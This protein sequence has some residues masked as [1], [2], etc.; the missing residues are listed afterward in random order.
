[1]DWKK[2]D[3]VGESCVWARCHDPNTAQSVCV[4]L[5]AH[6]KPCLGN[7]AYGLL[8]NICIRVAQRECIH[9]IL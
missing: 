1:M 2:G 4:K 9:Q 7:G 6:R 8:E 5:L 3:E